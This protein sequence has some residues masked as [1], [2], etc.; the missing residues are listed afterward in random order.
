MQKVNKLKG[1]AILIILTG[2]IIIGCGLYIY[3]VAHTIYPNPESR[4]V[5][6]LNWLLRNFGRL[7]TAAFVVL[8][9]CI[10]VFIGIGKLRRK[11]Q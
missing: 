5:K 2:L 3:F 8:I 6:E 9:G 10:S 1:E 11:N 7:P 4:R